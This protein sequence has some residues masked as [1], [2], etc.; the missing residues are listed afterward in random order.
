[1]KKIIVLLIAVITMSGA[2]FTQDK[3]YV[4]LG[5]G[6]G[7][8]TARTYDLC[9]T[10]DKVY[11]IGLGKGLGFNLR[12]GYF[13]GKNIALELGVGYRMGFSTKVEI[14]LDGPEGIKSSYGTEV[15]KFKGNMLSLVPAIL[16]SPSL[17]L[18]KV[19]PYARLGVI[20]GILPSII[21]KVD[22]TAPYG[23][24]TMSLK[25]YGGVAFGGSF[26]LGGD[27]NLSD[28]LA[29]YAEIYYDALSYAPTKGKITKYEVDGKDELPDLTTFDKEVEFVKDLTGFTPK[30]SEPDQQ[31]KNS[32]PF[33]SLGLNIG[34]K[35][36]FQ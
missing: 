23:N 26:A 9:M 5:A 3:A 11:P 20:I 17:D 7:I 4:S 36:R 13:L 34:V 33:N 15:L 18:G 30:D 24:S 8:G 1:M 29:I 28:L 6:V 25:Y 16:I 12:A 35:I 19:R 14:E 31:F 27:F 10:N 21:T 2:A 32:Y 22:V